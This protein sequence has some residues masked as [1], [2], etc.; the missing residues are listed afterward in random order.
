VPWFIKNYD[1]SEPVNISAGRRISIR[2]LAETV[3]KVT[4]FEGTIVWDTSKPDG[5]TDK[6]FSVA[7]LHALGL[8]CDTTLEDGLRRT[9]EWFLKAR[10]EGSVRL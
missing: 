6:I 4:G 2:E 10:Q 9:T 1:S 8:S 5:Q 7:R 3:K